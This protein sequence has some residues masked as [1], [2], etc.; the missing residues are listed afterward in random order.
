MALQLIADVV[1]PLA[2]LKHLFG[3]I[4]GLRHSALTRWYTQET[5]RTGK[6]WLGSS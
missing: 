3:K 1:L 4:L 6:I 2:K 5:R